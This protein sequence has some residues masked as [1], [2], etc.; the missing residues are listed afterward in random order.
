MHVIVWQFEAR[1][2]CV[3]EFEKHY[4]STGVWAQLFA[5]GA[6]YLG[7]RLW[8]D[9]ASP[10]RYLTFDLWET[11]AAYQAFAAAFQAEYRVL[12]E[13][14]ERLTVAEQRLVSFDTTGT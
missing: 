12:D 6:G 14:L 13:L 1:P 7:T 8:R 10:T 3:A 11:E 4:G 9:T 2:E 5:R